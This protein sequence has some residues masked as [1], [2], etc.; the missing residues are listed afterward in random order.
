M[1]RERKWR[2]NEEIADSNYG[3]CYFRMQR[4]TKLVKTAWSKKMKTLK[5]TFKMI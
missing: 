2:E 3:I 1:K 5:K 4:T